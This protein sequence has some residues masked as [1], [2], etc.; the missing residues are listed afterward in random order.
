MNKTTGRPSSQFFTLAEE[1]PFRR[2]DRPGWTWETEREL[3][4]E[5]A[6]I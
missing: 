6:Q 4:F 2:Q 5:H 1:S 3:V